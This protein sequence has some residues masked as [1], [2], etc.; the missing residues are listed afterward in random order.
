M[1]IKKTLIICFAIVLI[2][3]PSL[4][5]TYYVDYVSGSDSN[6]GTSTSTPWKHCPGDSNAT[7][8]PGST[9]LSGGDTI[10]FKGG[11]EYKGGVT[12]GSSGSSGSPI[13]FD[14]NSAG[15]WGTGDAIMDTDYDGTDSAFYLYNKSWIDIKNFE[16]REFVA[17]ESCL[18]G[19]SGVHVHAD[20]ADA[21]NINISNLYIHDISGWWLESDIDYTTCSSNTVDAPLGSYVQSLGVGVKLETDGETLS[22]IVVDN[23]EITK[24]G[25]TGIKIDSD[26]Q[27]GTDGVIDNVEIKNCEIHDYINW[28]VDISR[29]I[30]PTAKSY[31]TDVSFHDNEIYNLFWYS[32]EYWTGDCTAASGVN[33][34]LEDHGTNT[35]TNPHQNGMFIRYDQAS[36]TRVG[37]TLTNLQIYN[38]K[39][40]NNLTPDC[41]SYTS[42]GSTASGVRT[43]YQ[44]EG[45]TI[46]IY[47]NTFYTFQPAEEYLHLGWYYGA[48]IY[49][50]HNTFYN[51]SGDAF[52]GVLQLTPN[53]PEEKVFLRNNLFVTGDS[54]NDTQNQ[55]LALCSEGDGDDWRTSYSSDYNVYRLQTLG[56]NTNGTI[57]ATTGCTGLSEQT[58]LAGMQS[59]SGTYEDANSISTEQAV[60][61][62][63]SD[64]TNATL[65]N[66]NFHLVSGADAIDAAI[67][68]DTATYPGADTDADGNYR[69][70]TGVST[71]AGA[72][73]YTG[74]DLTSPTVTITSPATDPYDNG[75][76]NEINISITLTDNVEA[77]SAQWS[78]AGTGGAGS[79]SCS[80][81]TTSK[82]CSATV[83]LSPGGSAGDVITVTGYDS[84]SNTDTDQ[85]TVS[86][87]PVAV[88]D[89]STIGCAFGADMQ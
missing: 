23:V 47:N 81:T 80:G 59:T 43:S 57:L 33:S 46:Y 40:H 75:S 58:T 42:G 45:D 44:A 83:A 62:I 64:A 82:T 25:N 86:W 66:R 39:F 77:S 27:G 67:V 50:Y 49:V 26:P 70:A 51:D 88:E 1:N 71:D 4:A 85:V 22:N 56:E 30:V 37:A 84:S 10:I 32:Q 29:Y 69:G 17:D 14:G 11:V 76:D 60:N 24:V 65:A 19:G 48:S 52:G 16:I 2:A 53:P 35:G 21:G 7:G 41:A 28:G 3:V 79:M 20:T 74:D 18:K 87:T 12:V 31:I 54:G 73:L 78:N 68:L 55:I 38:N 8:N 36:T 15:T 61:S 72:Y 63:F 13:T 34:E 5:A 6:N 89:P 9:T